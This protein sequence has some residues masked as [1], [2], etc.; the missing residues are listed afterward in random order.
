MDKKSLINFEASE[1][2]PVRNV[3]ARLGDK[4]SILTLT[5]LKVNGK[6]RFSD[7]QRTIGDVSQRMLTVTLRAMEADGIISREIHA[8]VPP[9]VEYEL[10]EL[11]ESLYPHLQA[12]IDWATENI[13]T[14]MVG[15]NNL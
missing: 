11:G 6:L 7:I 14:I 4:W 10:T 1:Y 9:R 3:I 8:E 13:D 15:R 5:T 12:L 2:C